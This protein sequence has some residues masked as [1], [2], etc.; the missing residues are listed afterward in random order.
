MIPSLDIKI[1][2]ITGP[3]LRPEVFVT[4][5][6]GVATSQDWDAYS[7]VGYGGSFGYETNILGNI[8]NWNYLLPS[9]KS[10]IWEAPYAIEIVS[11]NEQ[12]INLNT[13]S[14]AIKF[15]T[16]DNLGNLV[17]GV[18][19]YF[20][21]LQG[22]GQLSNLKK[23]SDANGEI[24]VIYT[25]GIQTGVNYIESTLKNR[26][27]NTISSFG[28]IVN[29]ENYAPKLV[30]HSG[31]YDI[32]N[33]VAPN[34]KAFGTVKLVNTGNRD[35][36]ISGETI[37]W[38][39]RT[40]IGDILKGSGASETNQ[41][42]IAVFSFTMFEEDPDCGG[43]RLYAKYLED[44]IYVS[45]NRAYH[46]LKILIDIGIKEIIGSITL[47]LGGQEVVFTYDESTSVVIETVSIANENNSG[48]GTMRV[49]LE[50]PSNPDAKYGIIKIGG[51]C[52]VAG[53][54]TPQQFT[55]EFNGQT[56]PI[57]YY[58]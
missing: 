17:S 10:K 24:D 26:A 44:E 15:K 27:E 48:N 42:G 12:L 37:K 16:L 56:F 30:W 18:P 58:R 3:Y 33:I 43:Y 36:P 49:N 29:V 38:E 25:S 11:G 4:L 31:S 22:D 32:I 28:G 51:E 20:A 55:H 9:E 57:V 21:V 6:L 39:I 5:D 14:E 8:S 54:I 35:V 2:G 23:D 19:T 34:D 1:Y 53:I 47:A 40:A 7:E 50:Y 41:E 46:P 52:T 45:P 13:P